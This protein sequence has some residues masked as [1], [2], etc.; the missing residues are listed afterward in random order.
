MFSKFVKLVVIAVISFA[1]LTGCG[2][3]KVSNTQNS[4]NTGQKENFTIVTSFYPMYIAT[5]NV[6][7]GIPGIEVVNMTKPQTGCLHDYQLTPEDL[8]TLEKANA[9]VIN[10]AGMEAFLDKTIKQQPQLK[11]IDASKN[12]ELLKDETG[13]ENP[14]VWVSV[15]NAILQ[16]NNIAE[17]LAAVDTQNAAQYKNN[18]A[19]YVKKL[20]A[21]QD[22]MHKSL[23]GA[24]NKDIITF[25]EAFPY[26]AKEFK[27]T[28]VSVIER[29]PG[30][31]PSPAELEAT[32]NTIK[33]SHIKALF[34]EPQYSSKAAQT[35]AQETGAKVYTLDPVVTGEAKPDAYDAYIRTMEN[36]LKILQ[37]A[38]Q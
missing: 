17:Q 1:M 11:I 28:I 10:G 3:S 2:Q 4:I 12:L 14:H 25:H 33:K 20:E 38:L 16:V 30:S 21:L 13:E 18:A 6:T 24:K 37:E 22:T 9:F 31:E 32:I 27:L 8:K 5:I 34:A 23:D 7:K 15:S 29:E 36:N 35:I 26:F 19:E